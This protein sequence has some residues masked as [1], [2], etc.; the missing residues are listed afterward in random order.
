MNAVFTDVNVAFRHLVPALHHVMA[1]VW[2]TSRLAEPLLRDGGPLVR[3]SRDDTWRSCI[4][5]R[6]FLSRLGLQPECHNFHASGQAAQT[7]GLPALSCNDQ[8]VTHKRSKLRFRSAYRMIRFSMQN[9]QTSD[10]CCSGELGLFHY[11]CSCGG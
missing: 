6:V 7:Q 3:G 5:T 10:P 9:R 2:V 8:F 4:W 1:V 11:R